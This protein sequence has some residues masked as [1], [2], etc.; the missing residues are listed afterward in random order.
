MDTV[1]HY[2]KLTGVDIRN[3]IEEVVVGLSRHLGQIS[4]HTQGRRLR[5]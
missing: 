5:L 3:H 4:G 2:E 1:L